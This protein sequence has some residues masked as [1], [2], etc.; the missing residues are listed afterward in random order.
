MELCG[1]SRDGFEDNIKV[2]LGSW[3]NR[4]GMFGLNSTCSE[5]GLMANI[6]EHGNELSGSIKEE[7]L[8]DC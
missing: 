6:L 2:G 5:W 1:R 8:Q 4:M 7:N 3:R